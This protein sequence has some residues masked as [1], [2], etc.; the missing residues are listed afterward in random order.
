MLRAGK[1]FCLLAGFALSLTAP[2]HAAKTVHVPDWVR[3]AARTPLPTLR[4]HDAAVV[5]L[6]QSDITVDA[7][8][9]ATVHE[10]KVIKLLTAAGSEWATYPLYYDAAG[11]VRALHSWTIG[12]DDH[13]YQLDDKNMTDAS[14]VPNFAVFDSSRVRLAQAIDA[15]PGAIVAFESELEEPPYI[16]AWRYTLDA[17]IP[18]VG[19]SVT[20]ALPAG[21]HYSDGWA[22]MAAVQPEQVAPSTWRWQT[23]PR[24]SLD[25]EPGAPQMGELSA[26]M[27]VAFAG[28]GIAP[29]DG[30]WDAV[31]TWYAA[32][33]AGRDG[34][35][36]AIAAKVAE[37]TAGKPGFANKVL[38]LT[39]FMQDEIRYVAVEMGIGGWQ[40]HPAVDVF[41][42]RFGD[43]KDK[44]TLLT[45]MLADAGIRA[46]PVLVDFDH[47]L[48]LAMPSH[49][50][51]HMIVAIEVPDGLHDPALQTVAEWAGKRLLIF[52]PTNPVAP[53]GSLEPE[54]QG[55][56]GLV[57]AGKATAPLQLPTV[58]PEDNT[59]LRTGT[60]VLAPDGTLS[61]DIHEVRRGNTGDILRHLSLEGDARKLQQRAE[62]GLRESFSHFTLADFTIE[63]ARE[64]STPLE[65]D[66]HVMAAS[67]VKHAGDLLLV[68]PAVTDSYAPPGMNEQKPRLYPVALGKEEEVREDYTIQ[69]PGKLQPEDLP[70]PV[71]L[72]TDFATFDNS[73]TLSDG[74]LRYRST[75]RIRKLEIPASDYAKYRDFFSRVTAAERDE[76]L[77]KPVP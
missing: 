31:G 17:S 12:A 7:H 30:S 59:L 61:G 22:H 51:N 53:A 26:R 36:P 55:T 63:H 11:K 62:Q 57:L 43:C 23:G 9:R 60:F 27:M 74:V 58:P 13:E 19:H 6:D 70:D 75:L 44:A 71:H 47:R 76:A 67:Y 21:Y 48:D 8:G 34:S 42:N 16:T 32:L 66:F 39:G 56:Y 54:L 29:S 38:A 72:A 68:R 3:E 28:G 10:R 45:A 15:E 37:L 40:P 50:A 73:M 2:A 20:L 41:R 33:A 65:V 49:Y 52:D 5:L 64:R 4:Q 77:L 46:Y 1:H 69:L 24:A 14:A 35:S 18:S 25:E